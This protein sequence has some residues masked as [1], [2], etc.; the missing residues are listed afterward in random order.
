M[1]AMVTPWALREALLHNLV[2]F[3]RTP[4]TMLCTSGAVGKSMCCICHFVVHTLGYFGPM[5]LSNPGLSMQII[6]KLGRKS[7]L[8]LKCMSN[9]LKRMREK[10]KPI[11]KTMP[12]VWESTCL[13]KIP[14]YK[15]L[16]GFQHD[17]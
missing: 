9:R 4:I 14:H 16:F 17:L 13:S 2:E 11:T 5:F 12:N 15:M 1:D 3:G 8:L 6:R 7:I 10:N